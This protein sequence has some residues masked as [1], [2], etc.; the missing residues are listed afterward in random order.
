MDDATP[1][2]VSTA[3]GRVFAHAAPF[4]E[5]PYE[6]P[7]EQALPVFPSAP[8]YTEDSLSTLS[9]AQLIKQGF[10]RVPTGQIELLTLH[11]DA[12]S[13]SPTGYCYSS[14]MLMHAPL[15][16]TEESSDPHP[17][18]PARISGIHS[19]FAGNYVATHSVAPTTDSFYRSGGCTLSHVSNRRSGGSA[20]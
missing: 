17:E 15:P 19:K 11:S 16:S 6:I 18:Q 10:G 8:K 12:H 4:V 13:I 14:R 2:H 9:H 5:P 3:F 7:F 1:Q 20:K